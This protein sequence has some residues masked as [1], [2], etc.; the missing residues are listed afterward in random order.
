M[1]V[2]RAAFPLRMVDKA[3]FARLRRFLQESGYTEKAICERFHLKR[4]HDLLDIRGR[5]RRVDDPSKENDLFGLLAS[6]F[7]MGE[8]RE[9]KELQHRMPGDVY[10]ALESMGYLRDLESNSRQLY[11][12]ALLYPTGVCYFASDR[13]T[14]PEGT[15]I[16]YT[17][18]DLV[19]FG[20][21]KVTL[22]FGDVVSTAPSERF[23]ELGA[24]AGIVAMNA[25][26]TFATQ[27]WA[28]D[29]T[30]RSAQYLEF[31][32]Q[33]NGL[34][35]VTVVEGDLFAPV[36][37][38]KFDRI[39]GN[40]PFLP[41]LQ[42]K[43]IYAAGGEDGEAIVQRLVETVHEVL[44]PGGRVY[45]MTLGSDRRGD[46]FHDRVRRWLGER[47]DEFDVGIFLR[48][49]M[50][51]M[52]Y[53]L[54]ATVEN[55]G[56]LPALAN[57]GEFYT[58]LE[59]ERM[60]Y[61]HIVLQRRASERPVFHVRR[62]F[63]PRTGRTQIDWMLQ[64]LTEVMEGEAA[65]WMMDGNPVMSPHAELRVRHAMRNA[66]LTPLEYV[67]VTEHPFRADLHCPS[68]LARLVSMCNGS[69]TGRTLFKEVLG[70]GV[71]REKDPQTH[72]LEAMTA[73]VSGGFVK[74]E[75]H[76]PPE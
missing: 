71:L 73:L 29:L 11:A 65:V 45:V 3:Q 48:E 69:R 54:Q 2:G 13:Y 27:V 58:R 76:E 60:L 44:E 52:D 12:S 8:P 67:L 72:F 16:Y 66:D 7:L 64:T 31:N 70:Y 63:G 23:L 75:G 53:A 26:A 17:G 20:A 10:S 36:A 40:P 35:N 46:A 37:G 74:L 30:K 32:K 61:G 19:M 68:W 42:Q 49:V 25:A 4:L 39:A 59:V 22:D 15:G 50:Q 18:D 41:P 6:F 38:L 33:L 1:G 21:G 9:K 47:A 62:P 57:W 55:G 14:N 56:G 24:G 5:D 43:Y 34:E 28:T 51:P